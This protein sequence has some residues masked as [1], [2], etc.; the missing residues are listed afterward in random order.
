MEVLKAALLVLLEVLRELTR[1]MGQHDLS[2]KCET[3]RQEVEKSGT[4][5]ASGG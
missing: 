4:D 5:S 1:R 2:E 3:C